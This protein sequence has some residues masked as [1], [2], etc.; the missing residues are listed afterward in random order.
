M[1]P[2]FHILL[3]EDSRADA[4]I[5]E[6]ALRESKFDHRLTVFHDGRQ[7]LDYLIRVVEAGNGDAP[8]PDLVLLDLNLP[9][10]DG[11]QVLTEIKSHPNLRCIPVVILTTSPREEDV[12]QTYRAGANTYIQKPAE[13]PR[14][15]DLVRTL[16]LYW[17]ETA[18]RP[19]H[20]RPKL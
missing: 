17:H 8:E 14:Y 6:R 13:Y 12:L 3:I 5:I 1:R 15:R 20:I 4:K 7:A 10:I 2:E 11:C 18:L 19:P 16:R 9:G